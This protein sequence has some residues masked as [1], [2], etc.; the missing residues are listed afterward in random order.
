MSTYV[1]RAGE[2]LDFALKQF[3]IT[4]LNLV[5]A[6]FGSNTGGFVDCLL[7]NGASKVYTVE[8]VYGVL[9][10]N[11]RNNQ[12]VVVM[13]RTNALHVKLP[14]KIDLISVD[15]SWTPLSKIIPNI[16]NSLK[17]N[18]IIIVLLK[19]HYEYTA[20]NPN[21]H[22]GKLGLDPVKAE[23]TKDRVVSDIENTF[24]IKVKEV[25]KSPIKGNKSGNIEYLVLLANF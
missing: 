17:R 16:L 3:K 25:T 14:E 7:Q 24:K 13:E 12:K 21:E 18:G 11:L 9:D 4:P 23:E 10:W 19:P 1:S 8:T 5:C 15:V 22:L 20:L 2:K 6:D